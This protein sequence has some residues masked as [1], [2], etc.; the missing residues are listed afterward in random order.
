M[1]LCSITS[2]LLAPPFRLGICRPYYEC[3]DE[4]LDA[5]AEGGWSNAPRH[6]NILI[7]TLKEISNFSLLT[8]RWVM[9]VMPEPEGRQKVVP[10]K[11]DSQKRGRISAFL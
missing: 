2:R 7:R 11:E 9:L 8:V 1:Q 5:K 4:D 10:R 6:K 3:L